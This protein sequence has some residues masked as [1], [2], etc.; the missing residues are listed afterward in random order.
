MAHPDTRVAALGAELGVSER[1]LRRRFL[2]AVGYGPKTLARVLRFQRA[3]TLLRSGS[4]EDLAAVALDNARDY[5]LAEEDVI[6]WLREQPLD[7]RELEAKVAAAKRAERLAQLNALR[8]LAARG[9]SAAALAWIEDFLASDEPL[10]VF[11]R[12]QCARPPVRMST[13]FSATT[14]GLSPPSRCHRAVQLSAPARVKA[15]SFTSTGAIDPSS[16]PSVMRSRMA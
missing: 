8:R 9:K 5:K 4:D 3:V 11:A 2:D 13:I 7:L 14:C 10:V 1:Q 12:D 6:A 16:I 15:V